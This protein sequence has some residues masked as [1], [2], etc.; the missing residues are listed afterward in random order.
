MQ[1]R[2]VNHLHHV[3]AVQRRAAVARVAGGKAN[4]VIDD[5][6]HSAAG[7]VTTGFGQRERFHHH[8]LA[9][10]GGVAMHQDGQHLQ[11]L[12]VSAAVH[13]G[14]HRAFNYRVHNFK[15]RRVKRQR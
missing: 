1:Y 15:V 10:K 4:L 13:A 6:V 2:C 8:A 12:G 5:D 9:G 14:T 7:G 3:S 11:A